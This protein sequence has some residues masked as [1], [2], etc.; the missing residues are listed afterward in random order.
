MLQPR[1]YAEVLTEHVS[2]TLHPAT[3]LVT[4]LSKA[5]A[6][7]H[8][9]FTYCPQ[10]RLLA[11]DLSASRLRAVESSAALLGLGEV[12]TTQAGDLR[13]YAASV[14]GDKGAPDSQSQFDKVSVGARGLP[15]KVSDLSEQFGNLAKGLQVG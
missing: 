4:I 5:I 1:Y 2:R 10:G 11:M 8:F 6:R 3:A 15:P 14:A 13:E 7:S 12:L 9:I